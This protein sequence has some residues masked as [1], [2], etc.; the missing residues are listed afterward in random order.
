MFECTHFEVNAAQIE[1]FKLVYPGVDVFVELRKMDLWLDMNPDRRKKKY[2]RFINNWL[3]KTHG[4][5]LEAEVSTMVRE[6]IR[7]SRVPM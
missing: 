7:R 6:D 5:L 3:A 1:R 2:W 4:R